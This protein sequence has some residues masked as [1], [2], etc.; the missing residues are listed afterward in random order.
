MKHQK[1]IRSFMPDISSEEGFTIIEVIVSAAIV[2]ILS[3]LAV[4]AYVI[5]REDSYHAIAKQMMGN[6]R[7]SVEAGKVDSESF[8]GV[9][10]FTAS[11]PGPATDGD[12]ETIAPGLT[13]PADF[14]IQVI[15]NPNCA[16]VGCVED[17]IVTRHCKADQRVIYTRTYQLGSSTLF[18]SAAGGV[19]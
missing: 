10:Q 19:C 11:T 17:Y 8:A 16:I 5:Y 3:G 18:N 1:T 15:H 14:T 4:Q 13:L 2:A 7:T 6:T 9:L 12:S